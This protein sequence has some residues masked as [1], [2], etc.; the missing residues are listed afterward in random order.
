MFKYLEP[1]KTFGLDDETTNNILDNSYIYYKDN[2]L[3]Y[4]LK[5]NKNFA[6][7]FSCFLRFLRS[8]NSS[9]KIDEELFQ[10]YLRN[11]VLKGKPK[12]I[13]K[14]NNLINEIKLIQS[15]R[16]LFNSNNYIG[17]NEIV[18]KEKS[19]GKNYRYVNNFDFKIDVNISS[20]YNNRMLS[21][22][23][24][25]IFTFDDGSLLKIKVDLRL[26]NEIRKNLSLNIKKILFNENIALL[27]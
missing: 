14:L 4:Q 23:I 18:L 7:A 15:S 20:N 22:E 2:M 5:E 8:I 26:F 13:A 3:N 11:E 9:R 19:F 10:N 1:I 25:F 24:Y 27:K 12:T 17:F 6:M 16:I 21:P